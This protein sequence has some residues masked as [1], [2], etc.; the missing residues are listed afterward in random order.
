MASGSEIGNAYLKIL[1]KLSSNF[2]TE[3]RNQVEAKT[4]GIFR[5]S[6]DNAG[7]EFSAAFS[8]RAVAI[9]NMLADAIESAASLAMDGARAVIGGAFTNYADYEQL[10]GG[11]DKL[12]GDA[13]EQLQQYAAEAYK[14]AGMSAND[15]MEMSTS[16]AASLINSLGG[17]TQQAAEL[18]DLAMRLMSDNVN[19]FGSDIEDVK[20]AIM[21][22]SRD[23]FTMLDN[24]RLGYAG[25]KTGMQ[26]LVDDANEYAESIGLAGDMSMDSF[27]DMIRAIDLIQQ[28]QNIAGTTAREATQTISGSLSMLSASWQNLLTGLGDP[29]ADLGTLLENVFDSLGYVLANSIP[30]IEQI[31][32]GLAEAL[33]AA[34]ETAKP[35]L[36]ETLTSLFSDIWGA[37]EGTEI[38]GVLGDVFGVIQQTIDD[39]GGVFAK[40]QP[41]FDDA[42]ESFANIADTVGGALFDAFETIMAAVAPVVDLLLTLGEVS[43][44]A[45]ET[46]LEGLSGIADGIG[47]IFGDMAEG[48]GDFAELVQGQ[49]PEIRNSLSRVQRKLEESPDWVS[50]LRD[51]FG[52]VS[53]ALQPVVESLVDALPEAIEMLGELANTVGTGFAELFDAVSGIADALEPVISLLTPDFGT[54]CETIGAALRVIAESFEAIGNALDFAIGILAPSI[55]AW[56]EVFG[57][58]SDGETDA[59]TLADAL[60]GLADAMDFANGVIGDATEAITTAIQTMIDTILRILSPFIEAFKQDF[61]DAKEGAVEAIEGILPDIDWIPGAILEKFDSQPDDIA[62]KFSGVGGKV[63]A[64]LEGIKTAASSAAAAVPGY[65]SGVAG[66]IAAAIGTINFGVSWSSSSKG[67][68]SVDVPSLKPYAKYAE[69]G[70]LPDM[71]F[72]QVGEAGAE[73]ILPLE[74]IHMY[75][76]ADAVAERINA[77]GGGTNVYIDGARVNDDETITRLFYAFMNELNRKQRM[78]A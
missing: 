48:F 64:K 71:R 60:N 13:S 52:S 27:A 75:P 62:S 68:V 39:L 59:V 4:G 10:V 70:F 8:A 29:E 43:L 76:F 38:G 6:G 23:N 12:F 50:S 24:M 54:T 61:E 72:I 16:F 5:S 22:L 33:P 11:V 19:T 21:G 36:E 18:A 63:G 9:G 41:A 26:E 2:G 47:G 45:I 32:A 1:P 58:F 49:E 56:A 17:D 25:N 67:G 42:A 51:V 73:A 78:Y 20:N 35:L 55:D 28:K 77:A 69:G 53:D 44:P 15:Y 37:L 7:G 46:G 66:K 14:T 34:F 30:T 31:F 3:T 57:V 74:G 40:H 65:F